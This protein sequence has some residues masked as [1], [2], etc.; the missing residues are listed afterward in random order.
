MLA[1]VSSTHGPLILGIP[2]DST[3]VE[4]PI[5]WNVFRGN[6]PICVL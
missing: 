2:V 1:K 3:S 5:V 6:A 4:W